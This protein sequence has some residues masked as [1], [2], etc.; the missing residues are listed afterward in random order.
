MQANPGANPLD[1]K[2]RTGARLIDGFFQ[3]ERV[4]VDRREALPVEVNSTVLAAGLA[5]P[6]DADAAVVWQGLLKELHLL[7]RGLLHAQDV[8]PGPNEGRSQGVLSPRPIESFPRRSVILAT[9]DVPG[10]D[11]DEGR[12]RLRWRVWTA[13]AELQPNDQPEPARQDADEQHPSDGHDTMEQ[14]LA[15]GR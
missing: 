3:P 4:T 10:D 7:R 2:G 13:R 14:A 8:G 1:A 6:A 11:P 15:A 9:V 5:I 12:V